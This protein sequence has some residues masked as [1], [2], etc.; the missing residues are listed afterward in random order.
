MTNAYDSLQD[1]PQTG[2]SR[3]QFAPDERAE[4]RVLKV[5]SSP[6]RSSAGDY[7][8]S[9]TS[10]Y[11]LA[12]DESAAARRF[13]EVNAETIDRIDF[14]TSNVLHSNL[15]QELYDLVLHHAGERIREVYSTV[16]REDRPS[17]VTWVMDREHYDTSGRGR[18]SIGSAKVAKAPSGVSLKDVFRETLAGEPIQPATLE[19]AGIEGGVR[20]VLD[21]YR[22]ASDFPCSPTTVNGEL[23]VVPE[24]TLSQS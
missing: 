22:V 13:V 5:T 12:G 3:G 8:G 7:V 6:G 14:S 11:Y 4:V 1:E 15:P 10:I 2:L 16:V 23:A 18:Y 19:K 17:G 24:K 21:Y 20:Q 9:F